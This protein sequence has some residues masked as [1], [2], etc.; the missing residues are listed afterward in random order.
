[1][2]QGAILET[3]CELGELRE[4]LVNDTHPVKGI[5]RKTRV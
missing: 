2:S 3:F 4:L 5:H 1:M